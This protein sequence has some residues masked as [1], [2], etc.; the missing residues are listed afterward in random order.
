MFYEDDYRDVEPRIKLA[1]WSTN[2]ISDAVAEAVLWCI[3]N[4]YLLLN[5]HER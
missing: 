3:E 2:G 1:K 4:K 5:S